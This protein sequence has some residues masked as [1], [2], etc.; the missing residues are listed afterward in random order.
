MR[1]L[2]TSLVIV[3]A[4]IVILIVALIVISI[5]GVGIQTFTTITQAE[6]FCVSQCT[7]SCSITKTMPPTWNAVSV[8][9][10][11]DTKSCADVVKVST[12]TGK[13]KPA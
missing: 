11:A 12:C 5:F 8:K 10:G 3:V 7:A 1:G 6:S 13:C 2:H 4:A 9:V